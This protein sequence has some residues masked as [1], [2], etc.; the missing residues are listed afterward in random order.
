MSK[1]LLKYYF[2]R[3]LILI[4]PLVFLGLM[5]MYPTN[6][7]SRHRGDPAL[8]IAMLGGSCS[9]SFAIIMLF[10][11]IQNRINKKQFWIANLVLILIVTVPIVMFLYNM[12]VF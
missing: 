6:N 3:L 4:I 10:Q 11:L 12:G 7:N 2:I 8:E 5:L 1:A 9:L